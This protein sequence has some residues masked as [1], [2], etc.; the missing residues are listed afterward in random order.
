M[1]GAV[2]PI[3]AIDIS[4]AGGFGAARL[5]GGRAGRARARLRR[6]VYRALQARARRR[7]GAMRRSTCSFGAAAAPSTERRRTRPIALAGAVRRDAARARSRSSPTARALV[8]RRR[9]AQATRLRAG[10]A[11]SRTVGHRSPASR[12]RVRALHAAMVP[13]RTAARRRPLRAGLDANAGS[14]AAILA[15]RTTLS[16]SNALAQHFGNTRSRLRARPTRRTFPCC[17]LEVHA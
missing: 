9:R 7:A 5:D 14:R 15:L 17:A 1:P 2:T 8:V 13:M 4:Q 12:R 10:G 6:V 16:S 11:W 3:F